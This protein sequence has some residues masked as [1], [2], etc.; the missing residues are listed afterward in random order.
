MTQVSDSTCMAI[1]S[2]AITLLVLSWVYVP[3]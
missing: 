1:Y 2:I 3:A